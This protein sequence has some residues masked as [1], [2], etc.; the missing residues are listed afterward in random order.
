MTF[1]EKL[2]RVPPK[3]CR[4]AAHR[5][6]LPLSNQDLAIASGLSESTIAAISQLDV[7]DSVKLST[8]DR[9]TRA[10]GVDLLR[11]KELK[12]FLRAGL[13]Y[14]DNMSPTQRKMVRRITEDLKGGSRTYA[15][16]NAVQTR[17]NGSCSH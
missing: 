13:A 10:C 5:G 2:N 4:L 8:V 12:R 1:L 6:R 3:L 14:Q 9:F 17:I 16:V 7:W 15:A 11:L